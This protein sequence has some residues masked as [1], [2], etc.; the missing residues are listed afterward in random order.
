[1]FHCQGG[2]FV[3]RANKLTEL[4]TECFKSKKFCKIS[5][6]SIRITEKKLKIKKQNILNPRAR[7]NFHG[8]RESSVVGYLTD[9]SPNKVVFSGEPRSNRDS[10]VAIT[11]TAW[12]CRHFFLGVT[13]PP[14]NKRTTYNRNHSYST[15]SMQRG[16]KREIDS[17][18]VSWNRISKIVQ[19]EWLFQRVSHYILRLNGFFFRSV[20]IVDTKRLSSANLILFFSFSFNCVIIL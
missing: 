5:R 11:E 7:Y 1:M 18:T 12:S 8:N 4:T 15:F 10:Y 14:N 17:C 13:Q 20:R 2:K 16:G 6:K 19:T 9:F 3:A